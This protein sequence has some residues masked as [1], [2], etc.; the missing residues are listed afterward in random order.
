MVISQ[1]IL[2]ISTFFLLLGLA[3]MVMTKNIM[4]AC[5]FLLTVLLAV[6][7]L[8]ASM[9]A[10]F[11]A[12]AQIMVYVG[13]VVI[14]MLFAIMLTGGKDFQSR[15]QQLFS[16]TPLMGNARTYT[17]AALFSLTLV[18]TSVAVFYLSFRHLIKVSP[19]QFKATLDGIGTLLVTDYVLAFELSSVLLLGALIG[20][21]MIARQGKR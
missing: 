9:G 18:G 3:G 20:A 15:A 6:A 13:G 7:G 12:T 1:T 5:V 16:L 11:V 14:L 4:H 19:L 2:L 10:E 8:Y 21:A 17:I